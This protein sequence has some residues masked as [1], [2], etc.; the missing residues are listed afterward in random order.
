MKK[1]C[2][3][4][5]EAEEARV[6]FTLLHDGVQPNVGY[7]QFKDAMK[8]LENGGGVHCHYCLQPATHNNRRGYNVCDAK[9]E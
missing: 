6:V 7:L 9:H 2:R 3:V 1:P 5:L 4:V 8:K